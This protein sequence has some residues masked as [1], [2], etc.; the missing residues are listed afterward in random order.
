MKRSLVGI[1]AAS[2]TLLLLTACS[3]T[4]PAPATT[5]GAS[6]DLPASIASAGKIDFG[7]EL[8]V[9]PMTFF[10]SDGTTQTGVNHDLGQ[11]MA[12][13]LGVKAEFTQYAFPG[14]QPALKAGKIDAI[15]DVINDTKER[16]AQFDFIDYLASGD[17]LLVQH[18][19]PHHLAALSDM[20]GLSMSTVAGSVQIKLVEAASQKCTDDG[21]K[22]ITIQ[23]FPSAADARLQVQ[24]GKYDAFIGNTPVLLYLA[25]TADSGNAFSAVPL[26]G[27]TSYYGIAV[28]KSDTQLRDA[29]VTALTAVIADGTYGK[30][31][32]KYGLED[33]A[34]DKPLVNAAGS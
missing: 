26:Q 14:L 16:E 9:P 23:Q 27:D 7:A 2:A 12:E 10:E 6:G 17:T 4:A 24:N 29:L 22:P 31:L 8:T 21:D 34:L 32:A 20:C 3:S 19:N 15:F 13:H 11:A 5:G 28:D 1:A 25:K 33:L 18:G 30:V